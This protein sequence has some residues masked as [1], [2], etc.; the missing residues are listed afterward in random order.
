M[1][2]EIQSR[3]CSLRQN[4]KTVKVEVDVSGLPSVIKLSLCGRKPTL[5]KKF[6]AS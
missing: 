5:K 3:I 4:S 2:V 1:R 6:T